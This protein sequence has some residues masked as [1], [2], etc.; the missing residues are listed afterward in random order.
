MKHYEYK[1]MYADVCAEYLEACDADMFTDDN[2]MANSE[3]YADYFECAEFD[4]GGAQTYLGPHCRTDGF[5]I[6]IGIYKDEYCSSFVGDMVDME[7]LTCVVTNWS[8]IFPF[9]LHASQIRRGNL[10]ISTV[11]GGLH[12]HQ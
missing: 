5:T 1:C 12:G 9:R 2:Y 4:V 7:E 3:A 8:W 10:Y 11:D 6:G